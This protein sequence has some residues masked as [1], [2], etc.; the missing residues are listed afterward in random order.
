M[1]NSS[2]PNESATA[3]ACSVGRV[4]LTSTRG[5]RFSGGSSGNGPVVDNVSPSA[6]SA[7]APATRS[8]SSTSA[9]C[10]AQSSRG[11]SEYSRV[12]SRGSMIQTRRFVSRSLSSAASSDSTASAG[13]RA[14]RT[15]AMQRWEAASP[16]AFNCSATPPPARSRN[17]VAPAV[18]A[19]SAAA[20]ASRVLVFM[21]SYITQLR[22]FVKLP[23]SALPSLP[24]WG[25]HASEGP[26]RLQQVLGVVAGD[27]VVRVRD[28]QQDLCAVLAR[29]R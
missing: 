23:A 18:V 3:D 2:P 24:Y 7:T 20:A 10:T 16:A 19:M 22:R 9:T 5:G 1:G 8:P 15:S 13:K 28:T 27:E 11:G 26:Q 6:G 17:S 21:S 25:L 12:P 29:Q 14:A 4:R